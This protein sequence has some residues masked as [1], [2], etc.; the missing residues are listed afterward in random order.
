MPDGHKCAVSKARQ[1]PGCSHE[2][3]VYTLTR[4]LNATPVFA[5]EQQFANGKKQR[6]G[7]LFQILVSPVSHI[8]G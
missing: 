2:S 8:P 1:N 5:P 3:V 7:R 4:L 6:Q